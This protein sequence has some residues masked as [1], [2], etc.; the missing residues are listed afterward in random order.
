MSN[1][2]D[3]LYSFESTSPNQN[4]PATER[5]PLS[6]P[7]SLWFQRYGFRPH[8]TIINYDLLAKSCVLRFLIWVS[9]HLGI[10][11]SAS[12]ISRPADVPSVPGSIEIHGI[13]MACRLLR[14]LSNHI[15][16]LESTSPIFN[17]TTNQAVPSH[18]SISD[19]RFRRY[20]LPSYVTIFNYDLPARSCALC[21]LIR[22]SLHMRP[23]PV[24]DAICIYPVVLSNNT[25]RC[26]FML[27]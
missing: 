24:S 1:L 18:I 6:L 22:V 16:S 12:F 17:N 15:C 27:A 11:A 26:T 13:N 10:N 19:S 14:N 9:L 4:T 8:S 21:L 3:R 5:F 23:L 7:V 2:A 25:Q 20:G